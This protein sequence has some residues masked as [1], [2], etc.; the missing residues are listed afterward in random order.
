[1][2]VSKWISLMMAAAIIGWSGTLAAEQ[3]EID[4]FSDQQYESEAQMINE[5]ADLSDAN[6]KPK[7]NIE[8][9]I[10]KFLINSGLTI[11]LNA[12]DKYIVT[13]VQP[14]SEGINSVHFT[15]SK[16]MAYEKAYMDAQKEMLMQNFGRIAAEKV[17]EYFADDSNNTHDQFAEKVSQR[18]EAKSQLAR[19]LEKVNSLTEAKL[20][21]ALKN[22]GVDPK[23]FEGLE[24]KLRQDLFTD[25]IVKNTMRGFNSRS[26]YGFFVL[27]S[28][29]GVDENGAPAVGIVAAKSPISA[30]IARDM[31][32]Q[33][34]PSQVKENGRH[35]SELLP[36]EDENYL[37]EMGVR[38]FFDQTG[39][40]ALISHAQAA[41][42]YQGDNNSRKSK[43][44]NAARSKAVLQAQTQIAEFLNTLMSAED[45]EEKSES[46]ESYLE[47]RYSDVS[48]AV[49]IAE[50]E[51]NNIV[52]KTFHSARSSTR[53]DI[54]GMTEVAK[55]STKDANGLTVVG[56]V[57]MW[58]YDGLSAAKRV[59]TGKT[60]DYGA[61]K[62]QE[63]EAPKTKKAPAGVKGSKN[64]IHVDDF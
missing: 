21:N 62:K 51:V 35:V 31:A 1:M 39:R 44:M 43:Y 15:I 30:K 12:G 32:Q 54:A 36:D 58:S 14:I 16:M 48:G 18:E 60:H 2:K 20:D 50:K 25:A 57:V 49:E 4:V 61:S 11:G 13:K 29:Y 59:Q 7:T 63:K 38:L 37:A 6:F 23:K 64:V 41:S 27:K 40:P 8:K 22:E 52:D 56:S 5:A 34:T 28:F 45:R 3:N 53:A 17:R 42:T 33:R 10:S 26:L 24:K 19:I 47:N 46:D 9:E 55:W